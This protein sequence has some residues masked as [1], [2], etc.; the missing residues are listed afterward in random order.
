MLFEAKAVLTKVYGEDPALVVGDE[1]GIHEC[2]HGIPR[3][4]GTTKYTKIE[5]ILKT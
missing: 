3:G 4:K 2:H 5:D 1:V